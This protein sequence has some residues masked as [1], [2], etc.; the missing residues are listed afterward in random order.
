[1]DYTVFINSKID[2]NQPFELD[3]R[4]FDAAE[5]L[6]SNYLNNWMCVEIPTVPIVEELIL[7]A[8]TTLCYG[9][10]LF[11]E[12][13]G[14]YD[15]IEWSTGDITSSTFVSS[16]GLIH[17]SVIDSCGLIRNDSI[18]VEFDNV[19]EDLEITIIA[20]D[21]LEATGGIEIDCLDS[22][23]EYSLEEGD[24]QSDC[25]FEMLSAST[26]TLSI[27]NELGCIGDT[28]IMIP[29]DI[30]VGNKNIY[31]NTQLST[32]PNPAK[33][34]LNIQLEK[35]TIQ[36]LRIYN[37]MGQLLEKRKDSFSKVELIVSKYGTGIHIIEVQDQRGRIHRAK[38]IIDSF[39]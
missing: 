24:W 31:Y 3:Y 14:T 38:V 12:I 34:T 29:L 4:Y 37:L 15:F 25:Y 13:A 1:M 36:S 2:Y 21:S 27:R 30:N 23:L 20:S 18:M 28:L 22:S 5:Y 17:L 33:E 7:S 19:F 11:L 32:Y 8:D 10:N 35:G 9:D 26:Y 39:E 6:E 16:E